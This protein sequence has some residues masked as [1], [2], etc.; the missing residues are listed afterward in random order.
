MYKG[1]TT[2]DNNNKLIMRAFSCSLV[3]FAA[4][5]AAHKLWKT[6]T[7]NIAKLNI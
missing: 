2:N 1:Y 4:I 3:S 7:A 5:F 6:G